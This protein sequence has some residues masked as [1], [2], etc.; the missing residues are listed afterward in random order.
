MKALVGIDVGYRRIGVAVAKAGLHVAV[1]KGIIEYRKQKDA[2]RR[3]RDILLELD[4]RVLVY[5]LPLNSKGLI[6]EAA[7]AV[8]RF[9]E[10]LKA[11]L[12]EGIEIVEIDERFTTKEVH[13]LTNTSRPVDDLS[14]AIILNTYLEQCDSLN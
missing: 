7:K 14:A 1:P 4:A 10:G 12:P 3:I 8:R 13:R 9:I 6:G 2:Y 11:Y 5:G